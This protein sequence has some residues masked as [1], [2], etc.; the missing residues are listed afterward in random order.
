VRVNN[1]IR[2]RQVRVISEDGEQLGIMA[3]FDA[4][5]E[6]EG[7]GLDLVE[8]APLASPPVC[9]IMDYGKYRYEQKRRVREARKN[10]HTVT[11]KEVKYRPK[12]DKHDLEYKNGHVREFLEQ[13][14]K[15]KVTVMFRGREMAHPEFGKE[16]LQKVI[17]AT[18]DITAGDANADNLPIEGR[19]MSVVLSPSKAIMKKVASKVTAGGG[20]HSPG[21]TAKPAEPEHAE[22]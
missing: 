19:N 6:A 4:V 14:N 8:V 3:P 9:R 2:A 1:E 16:I 12:I 20:E 13:G 15:V 10:Q 5:R 21:A 22:E 17:E 11:V 7:R 18:N